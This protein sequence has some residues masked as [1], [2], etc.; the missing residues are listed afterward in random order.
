M[1]LAA[2][3]AKT[4]FGGEGPFP[5]GL[6]E[7]FLARAQLIKV[8]RGHIIISEGSETSEVYL[9]RTGKVQ[10]SLFSP[11]G[12]EVILR[13][14]VPDRIFGELAAIDRQPRSA[15]VIALEESLLARMRGDAFLDFLGTVPQA[16]LWMS[17]VLTA[18]I[19]DLTARAFELAT[20]PVAGRVQ[21][22]LLRLARETEVEGDRL[23]ISPMPTHADL[24][25]WIGTHREAVTRELN[26][27]AGE[28]ILRQSGREAEILS[29]S[30][31]QSLYNRFRG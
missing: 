12:R 16:G 6:R 25:A 13:E 11:H 9:L 7:A 31:L 19:R 17:E 5:D 4:S 30:R 23:V 1:K 26:L 24:A 10:I 28:G 18:R 2:E 20:L 21:S 3:N 15:N 27:L 22:E 29:L 8:R 14:L